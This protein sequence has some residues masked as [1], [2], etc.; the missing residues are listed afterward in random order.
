[1][2]A[3]ENDRGFRDMD[4]SCD[5]GGGGEMWNELNTKLYN[6][7]NYITDDEYW[8]EHYVMMNELNRIH[9]Y[10]IGDITYRV[11]NNY[12]MEQLQFLM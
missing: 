3:D 9:N 2:G 6:W 1:M 10:R 8:I 5:T 4:A 7:G 12:Y 11:M